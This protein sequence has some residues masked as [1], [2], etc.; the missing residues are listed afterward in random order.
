M[1]N[2]MMEAETKGLRE[3]I[4]WCC[5]R[6]D[7]EKCTFVL[8][9]GQVSSFFSHIDGAKVELLVG[10]LASRLLPL[11]YEYA[12]TQITVSLKG[13]RMVSWR[14]WRP[15]EVVGMLVRFV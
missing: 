11:P 8:L 7:S 15:L 4:D 13:G 1:A 2:H 3:V 12:H 6:V 9:L 10:F 5:F 14:L